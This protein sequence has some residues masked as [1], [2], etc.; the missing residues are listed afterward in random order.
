MISI[1]LL[2][3]DQLIMQ[4]CCQSNGDLTYLCNAFPEFSLKTQTNYGTKEPE[5]VNVS[6][7]YGIVSQKYSIY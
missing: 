3:Q 2:Q 5:L 1:N 7:N 4:H 6:H